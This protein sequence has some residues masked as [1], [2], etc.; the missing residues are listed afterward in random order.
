VQRLIE[1]QG[2]RKKGQRHYHGH[3]VGSKVWLEGANLKLTHPKAKL[4]A[5][6]Y[7]PFLVTKAISPV[8]FQLALPPQWRIHDVFHALLLTPY[9]EMEEYGENFTQPPPELIEGQ[10]EYEV[11]WIMDSRRWGRARKLQY[12]L[13]WKGYSCAHNSWQDATEVHAPKLVK[14]YHARKKGAVRVISI[15]GGEQSST[16]ASPLP[17]INC[18]TMSNGSS[19]P[20]STFSFI[21]P[22]TDCEET[23]TAGTTNDNQYDDQV[24]LFGARG[25][26]SVGVD[27]SLTDF[28]PLGV[29]IVLCN[30]W[31]NP[32]AVYS[33]DTWWATFQ[34]DGSEASESGG[35]DVPSRP[36]APVNWAGPES[37]FFIPTRDT[38]PL[39]PRDAVEPTIAPT[40][41]HTP[42]P[43]GLTSTATANLPPQ[44]LSLPPPPAHMPPQTMVAML[45]TPYGL[46]TR[47]V[48]TTVPA[49]ATL[50][51]RQ[52]VIVVESV[53]PS[54][55]M[56]PSDV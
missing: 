17:S 2:K 7:G 47:L 52:G 38:Y 33:N 19:S 3:A 34:D 51:L 24:V 40:P 36:R 6:R 12:L 23:P 37:P 16:N 45:I 41:P 14:E 5:K 56:P 26:Q 50:E 46:V 35:S 10:E 28:D 42:L 39:D 9:K 49:T 22:T 15:K 27:P 30:A 11:E 44:A 8:V 48:T 43:I 29:D 31:Y 32:E 20:A 53:P 4:D 55:T 21:Y 54:S 1:Q 13:R 18:I 25:Q